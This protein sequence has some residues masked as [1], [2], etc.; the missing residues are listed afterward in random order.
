MASRNFYIQLIIRVL[1]ITAT[2]VLIAFSVVERWYLILFVAVI[3]LISQVYDLIRFINSTNRKIAYF[4]DAIKNEDFTLRFPE[5]VTIKSFKE[6]NQSLNRV[7]GLIQ[8]VHLQL[9]I[10]EKYYQEILKQANIGIMTFNDKGHILFSNP[11]LERLLNYKPLNHIKQLKQI[12]PNLYAVFE[13]FQPFERKLFQL[14]NEREQ[15]QLALKSTPVV[16]DENPLLLVVVQDINEELDEKETDSWIRLIRVLTHEIMNT[17]TPITSIS[18]SILKYYHKSDGEVVEQLEK[19]KISSAARGLEVIK[20]QGHDLMEF[21]QGYRSFLNVPKPDRTLVPVEKLFEKVK[22]LMQLDVSGRIK[23]Q[24]IQTVKELDYFIDEK[25]LTQVLINLVKNAVHSL[26]NQNSGCIEVISGIDKK[27]RKYIMVR[28]DGP[29]I[30]E[31]MLD[32]IFIPF[33]T[34]KEKGT[35][36]GLSLSRQIMQLHGGTLKLYSKPNE[37]TTFTMTF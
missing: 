30:P 19:N 3:A 16:L 24:W 28:D 26:E 10:R 31:E 17:I 36:I 25:Q 18:E 11:T 5:R 29:G 6:L 2:A 21:V 33:F 14:T 22:V 37:E 35:G 23:I 20:N 8:E 15:T 4:F 12:D 9:Q 32:E 13:S 27:R 34:T 1:L 7:N